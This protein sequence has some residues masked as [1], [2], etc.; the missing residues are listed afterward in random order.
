M[1]KR[2]VVFLVLGALAMFAGT[3]YAATYGSMDVPRS[4]ITEVYDG[5][6]IYIDLQQ[7]PG[8]FG[9]HI[10]VRIN[11]I[12][13]PEKHSQCPD[14]TAK[15]SEESKALLARAELTNLLDSGQPIQLRNVSRDK[16]FR[17]LAE[18]WVGNQNVADVLIS[19]K[20]GVPYHGEKKVGWCG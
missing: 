1:L 15:A 16:Y 12:D 13:T 20:L 4:A 18:V 11:G 9:Q 7:I 5:D 10:G 14:P 3:A 19:K 17:L 6:T 8:V 2:S